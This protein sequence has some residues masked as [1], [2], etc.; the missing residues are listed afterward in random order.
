M[1]VDINKNLNN[2][3][4]NKG[5]SLTLPIWAWA[6][7]ILFTVG[8]LCTGAVSKVNASYDTV[9]INGHIVAVFNSG[10]CIVD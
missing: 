8:I 5:V 1:V 6:L 7:V 3:N 10:V 4:M 2:K 9:R